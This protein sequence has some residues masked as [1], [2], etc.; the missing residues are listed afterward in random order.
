MLLCAATSHGV[1]L[2][3]NSQAMPKALLARKRPQ[4]GEAPGFGRLILAVYHHP[5]KIQLFPQFST[6]M[7]QFASGRGIEFT[8]KTRFFRTLEPVDG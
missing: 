8:D 5:P 7:S 3:Q 6:K 1:L 4:S 2:M